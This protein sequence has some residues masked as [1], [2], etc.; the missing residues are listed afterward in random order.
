MDSPEGEG[1]CPPPLSFLSLSLVPFPCSISCDSSPPIFPMQ[2]GS[3]ARC[4]ATD[5]QVAGPKLVSDRRLGSFR[6]P[7]GRHLRIHDKSQLP[8]CNYVSPPRQYIRHVFLCAGCRGR[9]SFSASPRHR[10]HWLLC[11]NCLRRLPQVSKILP[12]A[13]IELPVPPPRP[14]T[15]LPCQGIA[16]QRSSSVPEVKFSSRAQV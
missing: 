16:F 8:R 15:M 11:R 2:F 13:A 7:S 12:P 5:G 6:I 14:A 1:W 10:L 9:V 4:K 3:T